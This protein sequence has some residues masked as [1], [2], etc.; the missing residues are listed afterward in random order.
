VS[1]GARGQLDWTTRIEI[2]KT[3]LKHGRGQAQRELDKTKAELEEARIELAELRMGRAGVA[4]YRQLYLE[5][6]QE[7][8]HLRARLDKTKAE[9]VLVEALL[10]VHQ[11]TVGRYRQANDDLAQAYC[12]AASELGT[13]KARLREL[14][15]DTE[16]G[17]K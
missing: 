9:L 2:Y 13:L 10:E 3:G 16:G 6:A 7:C 8:K 14:A 17:G 4:H 15:G 5:H 1:T 11:G 12:T